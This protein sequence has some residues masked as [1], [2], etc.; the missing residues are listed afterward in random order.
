MVEV[1]Q[2]VVEAARDGN[3]YKLIDLLK[4]SDVVQ[5]LEKKDSVRS[6]K[7]F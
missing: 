3:L 4:N 1:H 7:K 5:L 6:I 2:Q